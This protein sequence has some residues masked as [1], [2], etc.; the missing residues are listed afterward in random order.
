MAPR[1][2][3]WSLSPFAGKVRVAFAEKGV[4]VQ[5]IEIDPLHRPA[6]LRELNPTNRVPVLEVDGLAI[7]ESSAICDWLEDVHPLP[8]LWPED[9]ARRAAARGLMRWVDDELTASFFLSIRKQAFGLDRSDH[10]DIV[11]ILRARLQ[12]RWPTLE[13]LLGR[14]P[15]PWLAGNGQP[16]L[17]DLAAIPLAVRLPAWMPELAPAATAQPLAAAWLQALRERP[18]AAEVDRRG[19]PP[20]A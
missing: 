6:R 1:L 15:G 8:S 2:W 10:P 9:P 4:E 18:S 14:S 16:T 19:M 7:R 17:A 12:R 5:L 3:S 13:S 11:A 20:A